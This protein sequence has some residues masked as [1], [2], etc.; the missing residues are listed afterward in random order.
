[1]SQVIVRAPSHL[2]EVLDCAS[3]FAKGIHPFRWMMNA[4]TR[5]APLCEKCAAPRCPGGVLPPTGPG[6]AGS[7]GGP[8]PPASARIA[9]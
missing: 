3:C 2:R 1:M 6:L 7:E 9:P 4:G 5:H 8:S